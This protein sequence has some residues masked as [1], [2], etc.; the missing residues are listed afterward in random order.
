[1]FI[2]QVQG[3]KSGG[4][5]TDVHVNSE[6]NVQEC[7][8]NSSMWVEVLP[9]EMIRFGRRRPIALQEE[10]RVSLV[11]VSRFPLESS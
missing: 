4:S 8:V 3:R 7:Q 9:V 5:A 11:E 10:G 2:V 1:M 6:E